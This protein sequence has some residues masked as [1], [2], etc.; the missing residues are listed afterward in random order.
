MATRRRPP[1]STS[2]RSLLTN[3][4]DVVVDDDGQSLYLRQN[5][6]L[7]D[8]AGIGCGPYRTEVE[9]RRTEGGFNA[10]SDRQLANHIVAGE[11]DRAAGRRSQQFRPVQLRPSA[12]SAVRW[13]PIGSSVMMSRIS[14]TIARRVPTHQGHLG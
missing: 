5:R 8:A 1:C 6:K 9:L 12:V 7:G 4:I 2:P 14:A 11:L 13:M 10:F 3:A